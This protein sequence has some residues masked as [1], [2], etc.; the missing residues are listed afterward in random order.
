[1]T[2]DPKDARDRAE[3]RFEKT[4]P[5]RGYWSARR[6]AV[7]LLVVGVVAVAGLLAFN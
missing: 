6:I 5:K 2:H 3:E 4:L 1:M 7:A